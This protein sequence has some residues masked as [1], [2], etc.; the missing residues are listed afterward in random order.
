MR[1]VPPHGST[2]PTGTASRDRESSRHP[3]PRG[4]TDLS[5]TGSRDADRRAIRYRT[6]VL[7]SLTLGVVMRIAEP[8]ATETVGKLSRKNFFEKSWATIDL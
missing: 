3:Y 5:D 6:V 8:P 4:G 2:D 1:S 7:T